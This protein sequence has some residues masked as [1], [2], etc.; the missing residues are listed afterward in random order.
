MF[1]FIIIILILV[2]A[3]VYVKRAYLS[4]VKQTKNQI[5]FDYLLLLSL[6]VLTLIEVGRVLLNN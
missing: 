5:I 3:G 4:K 6:I 2:G 1:S